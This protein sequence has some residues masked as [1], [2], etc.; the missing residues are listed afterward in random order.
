MAIQQPARRLV[1]QQD[2]ATIANPRIPRSTFFNKWT[3]KTAFDA[4][5]LIPVFWDL[6]LPGDHMRYNIRAFLRS[7]PP[8]FPLMDS[9]V[10][11]MHIFYVPMRL[12]WDNF[13]RFMGQQDA[14]NDSIAYTM[15]RLT[16]IGAATGSIYD[17]FG[18][19]TTGQLDSGGH[20]IMS[21]PFRA[22]NLIYNQWFRDEN[23][24]APAAF[25]KANGPDNLSWYNILN[26]AKS[27][28]YF[29]SALP[30]PQK[31][32]TTN[33]P[34]AGDAPVKGIGKFNQSFVLT[35]AAVWQT[36]GAANYPIAA[37]PIDATNANDRFY[38][39]GTAAGTGLPMI[40]ADLSAVSGISINTLRQAWM[41]QSMHER[42]ARYGT[43]YTEINL[44]HFGIKSSDAR[45]QRPEY[46]GGGRAPLVTTA[47][48]QTTPVTAP[49]PTTVGT[50][51]GATT[52]G[53][54]YSAS[55]ASE[56]HGFIIGIMSIKSEISYQQGINRLWKIL[57]R[58]EMYWPS[59]AELGEQPIYNFELWVDGNAADLDTFGYQERYHEYRT[60]QSEVTGIMKSYATGTLDQWHLAQRF[61]TR[62]ALNQ[63]F[64][65]D[66]PPMA[67]VLSGGVNTTNQQYLA[68]ISF[69]RTATRPIPT[70]GTPA[71]FGRF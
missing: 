21:L 68:D 39:Q 32:G 69:E 6:I 67:R 63:A 16:L 10:V 71:S 2:S 19:P 29:T 54:N 45:L 35:N 5:K 62:P 27:H 22:Y 34:L 25:T 40:Y 9:Q 28:D 12:L 59:Y 60:K 51:G 13:E 65:E 11:D 4:G 1:S 66:T 36:S 46:I 18:L 8:V 64:I 37:G 7:N 14:P 43:R 41:M 31:F 48:P 30:W 50:L 70:H 47:V 26:R 61:T 58:D 42:D 38:V 20:A 49:T 44:G 52:A 24:A 55:Y 57:T 23:L 33:I 3:R 56:E 53:G 17:H 15:P